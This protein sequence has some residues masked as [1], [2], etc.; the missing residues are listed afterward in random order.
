MCLLILVEYGI[1]KKVMNIVASKSNVSFNTNVS[2][3]DVAREKQRV[4]NLL[5]QGNNVYT[6]W[7][8]NYIN[9]LL[10]CTTDCKC[11]EGI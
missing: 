2:D 4:S 11:R 1:L 8:M 5:Q 7:F 10:F 6:T 9:G 3:D